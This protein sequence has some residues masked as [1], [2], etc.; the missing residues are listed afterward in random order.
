MPVVIFKLYVYGERESLRFTI[1]TCMQPMVQTPRLGFPES[2]LTSRSSMSYREAESLVPVG[3]LT[4]GV[5][6]MTCYRKNRDLNELPFYYLAFFHIFFQKF[7][8]S[9]IVRI[10]QLADCQKPVI[11]GLFSLH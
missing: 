7:R 1:R 9:F 5:L 8:S 11:H 3:V 2:L 10:Y 4:S 6:R